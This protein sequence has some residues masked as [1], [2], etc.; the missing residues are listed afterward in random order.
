MS[1]IANKL[2]TLSLN[3]A[4]KPIGYKTVKDAIIGLTGSE[5][6]PDP[7]SLA[8]DI[9]YE[10]DDNGQPIFDNVINMRPVSWSE[11]ITLPIRDWDLSISGTNRSYRVPTVIVAVNYD[12]M[13]RKE[14]T[15]RPS[16]DSILFRDDNTCQVTGQKLPRNL[17][18]VDHVIPKSRG[19]TDD[20]E[21]LVT[22]RKDINSKKGNKLNSEV[23]IQLIRP[24]KRPRGIDV[25]YLIKEAR[26]K[27]HGHF[28]IKN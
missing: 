4:W 13:P 7:T 22:I 1:D 25:M 5:G 18:N 8:L 10:L 12:K 16:K 14:F 9:E 17:L 28:I 15:G 24:P 2:I 6:K 20:W 23:G 21:N 26:H 19:G 11:W 27:D 3:S